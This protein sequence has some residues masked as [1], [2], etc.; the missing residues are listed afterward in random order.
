MAGTTATTVIDVVDPTTG[1]PVATAPRNEALR[2]GLAVRTVHGFLFDR[3][4]RLLLQQLGRERDRHP[5]L[6]GSSVA[7]FP[8]PGESSDAA[9]SRRLVEELGLDQRL[10]RFGT[11]QVVDG[12]SPKFVTLYSGP[13]GSPH[14]LEPGHV[15]LLEYWTLDAV[16]AEIQANSRLFTDTFRQ[17]YRW[18][19]DRTRA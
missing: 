6:W 3:D 7:G 2:N 1:R 9:I 12:R 18:W 19:R 11:V 14:I 5:L 13:A 15:E 16:D 4:Q 17:V 10:T 8:L